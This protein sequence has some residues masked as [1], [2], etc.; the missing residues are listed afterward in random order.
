MR[1]APTLA[2]GALRIKLVDVL[3]HP[4]E[5]DSYIRMVRVCDHV[6]DRALVNDPGNSVLHIAEGVKM[7][8]ERNGM[9]YR[10]NGVRRV[11][12]HDAKKTPMKYFRI[13]DRCGS[14]QPCSRR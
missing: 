10:E 11:W 1:L 8:A 2:I 4:E 3:E 9:L 13:N 14:L 6:V 5:K 12:P 7:S